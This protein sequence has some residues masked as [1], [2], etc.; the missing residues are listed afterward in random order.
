MKIEKLVV[1]NLETNCY[2]VV[3]NHDEVIIIDPGDEVKQIIKVVNERNV[4]GILVTHAHFD[5]IGALDELEQKYNLKHNSFR[6]K[7]FDFEVIETPGHRFDCKTFYFKKEN[8]MFTGDFLFEGTFGRIDLPG[9]DPKEMLESLIKIK[10]YPENI[11]LYPG[12]GGKTLLN[13]KEINSY[14]NYFL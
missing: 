13:Y 7:N 1:G 6:I 3:N 12:H 10:K 4:V 14:I 9:S 2:L 5:H 11:I 8:L